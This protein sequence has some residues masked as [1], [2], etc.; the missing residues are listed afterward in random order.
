MRLLLVALEREPDIVL[1]RKRTRR[2]AELLGFDRQDQTR[3]TTAISELARNALEYAGGGHA[4]FR[5]RDDAPTGALEIL[6]RDTGPGIADLDAVLSGTRP[7]EKGMGVG[8]RGA[9]RLMDAFHIEAPTGVGTTVRVTKS[10]PARALPVNR[11][12]LTRI[13]QALAADAPADPVDEIRRQNQEMLQQLQELQDRQE[14]L[15]QLNQELQDTNR[16]VVALYAE[17][18]ERA[19]H[20]RRADE[21]KSKFLS[22]M[23]HEFRTPLNSVLALSRLLLARA[24]GELT[25]EQEKQVQYIRK[26]AESLTE[27]VNDLLDL[28]K[29]EAGKTVVT[30]VEFAVEDLFGAL[31]GM[32]RPLLVSDVVALIFE[33]AVDLPPLQTDEGKVSQILRNFLSNAIKFT[34]RGEVRVWATADPGVD[35]VTFHVRDTGIGIAEEDL[36]LIFEEFGQVT[37]PMQSR[38]KGTG[39]G[40]PLSKRLAELLGGGIAVQ[41]AP[42]QG[43]V[44]SVTLPRIY[45]VA[46]L[47]EAEEGDWVL[48]P[49]RIPVLVVEDNPADAFAVQRVLHASRYQPIV[50]STVAAAKRAFER[51]QP[52]VVLLDVVLFGDESWRMILGLRQA[53]ATDDTPIIVVSST[54]EERKALHL[55][56]DA[57]LRKPIDRESLIEMLDRLSG[58]RSRTRVLLVDDEEITRYLVRQLLPRG[59]YDLREAKT[60]T[61]GWTQLLNEPPDVLLLDLKMPEMTGFELLDRIRDEAS[62][63]TVPAIVLT[64][65]IL[66]PA[67]RERLRRAVCIMSKSDLSASALV[68]TITNVLGGSPSTAV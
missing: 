46:E 49:S 67:E 35:T 44:F 36:G 63:S 25:P 57:Y 37:H 1:I 22:N 26:A 24:D 10:L 7:S 59:L 52:A 40:L 62:L 45:H 28:A 66:N 38:I 32:L 55:G 13:G 39:L 47:V 19:D 18:D 42:G 5:I 4:E 54:S 14:A 29:V 34:E 53:E 56:A 15:S 50:V 21:L 17:L 6:I 16:G 20:L 65:A 31:R 8:L 3:I 30:P 61:E 51:V 43:S 27:L 64:S 58:N 68:G 60:G 41:S 2:I 9:Q 12:A 23:S 48:D 33:D 11:A